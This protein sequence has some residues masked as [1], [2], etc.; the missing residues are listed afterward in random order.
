MASQASWPRDMPADSLE[1]GNLGIWKSRNLEI[2]ESG[3][4]KK[5]KG[6]KITRMLIRSDQNV[7]KVLIGKEQKKHPA[8]FAVFP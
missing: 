6:V 7:G 1:S 5:Q 3:I 4:P 8:L 2:W